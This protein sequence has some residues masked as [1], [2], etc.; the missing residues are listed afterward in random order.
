M[1]GRACAPHDAAQVAL[2]HVD[3]VGDGQVGRHALAPERRP[4]AARGRAVVEGGEPGRLKCDRAVDAVT[5]HRAADRR[6]AAQRVACGT[7]LLSHV[8]N[9]AAQ[10]TALCSQ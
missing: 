5:Q 2:A 9:E 10:A 1:T 8:L 3:G 6:E 4:A 7:R